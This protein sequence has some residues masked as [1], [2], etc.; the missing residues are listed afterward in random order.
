MTISLF[1]S[2]R[3]LNLMHI[4]VKVL[5]EL[6]KYWVFSLSPILWLDI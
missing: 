3:N 5:K 2:L 4:D 6:Q 1:Q